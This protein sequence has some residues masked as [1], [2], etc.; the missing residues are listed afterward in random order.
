M[1]QIFPVNG[2][3]QPAEMAEVLYTEVGPFLQNPGRTEFER[4]WIDDNT[5]MELLEYQNDW[6]ARATKYLCRTQSWDLCFVQ[7]HTPDY[8]S[9]Y[10]ITDLDPVSGRERDRH[11]NAK[12]QVARA[13]S[14]I[15]RF[16]GDVM[17]AGD[18][19][20]LIILASDHGGTANPIGRHSVNRVLAQAGLLTY[21]QDPETGLRLIDWSKTKAVKQRAI[22]IYVNLKGRDP[23]GIVPEEEYEAVRQQ[24]IDALLSHQDKE[25]GKRVYA[26]A[27]RR[28]E[29]ISLGQ[30]SERSG[31][32]IF[33]VSPEFD[34]NHGAQ[35]P[36]T[37]FGK[38]SMRAIL[39]M[40]GPGI[41]RGYHLTRTAF[42]TDIVPTVVNVMRL[43]VPRGCEGSI[44]YEALED[45]DVLLKELLRAR[46][47][48]ERWRKAYDAYRKL[49]HLDIE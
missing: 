27:I 14:S 19:K 46:D 30:G 4:G 9:H 43:P 28:E 11:E 29:A 23:A 38:Y 26:M 22:H 32:V 34:E 12:Q 2:Y 33:S 1:P 49:T 5:F 47:E 6:L 16:V 42:T 24:I 10:Y 36:G 17:T 44:L 39:I 3:I 13:L 25:T 8:L 41:K 21:R 7:S 35:L 31:D 45:P 40:A 20:T 37:R 15:D 18:E 48:A